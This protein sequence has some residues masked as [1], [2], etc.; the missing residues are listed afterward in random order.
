MTTAIPTRDGL[1]DREVWYDPKTGEPT[2]RWNADVKHWERYTEDPIPGLDAIP[3][4]MPDAPEG[5]MPLHYD[6]Q[7]FNALVSANTA[8]QT[9]ISSLEGKIQM[10]VEAGERDREAIANYEESVG[11][12]QAMRR[13]DRATIKL[14]TET[15][16]EQS[17]TLKELTAINES[18]TKSLNYEL[19]R[20][21]ALNLQ[22]ERMKGYLDRTLEQDEQFDKTPA[23]PEQPIMRPRGPRIGEIAMPVR[24]SQSARY[25][26]A[27][28]IVGRATAGTQRPSRT[29]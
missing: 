27:A 6:L 20:S 13:E 24:E 10:L 4:D 15:N 17:K 5:D 25:W 28:E 29:F 19:E 8:Q 3:A 2:H 1:N 9:E 26:D 12:L 16:A 11:D 21:T 7:T 14:L 18:H 22:L 23:I